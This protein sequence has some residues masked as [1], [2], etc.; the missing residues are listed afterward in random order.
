MQNKKTTCAFH[1][2]NTTRRSLNMPLT[3][4]VQP[5][6]S[7][8]Q[9]SG[10]GGESC[11]SGIHPWGPVSQFQVWYPTLKAWCPTLPCKSCFQGLVS[12]LALQVLFPTLKV[13]FPILKVW[14]P[15]LGR[16]L[17]AASCNLGVFLIHQFINY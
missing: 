8:I 10:P 2:F 7:G 14:C 12:N 5:C 15:T 1:F 13:W 16:S 17:A 11:R 6:R 4:G 3:S 9:P